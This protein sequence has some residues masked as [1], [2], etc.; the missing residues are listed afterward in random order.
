MK[1]NFDHSKSPN[2]HTEN[3]SADKLQEPES[4]KQPPSSPQ[5]IALAAAV[6]LTDKVQT[7]VNTSS[8][9]QEKSLFKVQAVTKSKDEK[10]PYF[11]KKQAFT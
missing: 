8:V 1:S 10:T 9:S 6:R 2:C 7:E 4:A 11:A 5:G 3:T